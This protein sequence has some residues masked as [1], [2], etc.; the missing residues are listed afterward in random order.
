M[1]C[2]SCWNCLCLTEDARENR[3]EREVVTREVIEHRTG[4]L[5]ASTQPPSKL[6]DPHP[7]PH[8]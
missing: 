2:I 5:E 4:K 8:I 7:D 3:P 6:P 1:F